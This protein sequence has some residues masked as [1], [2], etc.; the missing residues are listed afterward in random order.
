MRDAAAGNAAAG[1]LAPAGHLPARRVRAAS[2]QGAGAVRDTRIVIFGD[3]SAGKTRFLYASLNSLITAT[4]PAPPPVEFTDGES[5][6]QV[7][8]GLTAIRSGQDTVKTTTGLP[9]AVTCQLGTGHRAALA[10]LFDTAG[11]NYRDARCTTPSDS[12]TRGTGS[13]TSWT[14]SRSPGCATIWPGTTPRRSRLAH[15]AAGHPESAYAEVVSRIRDSGVP[16]DG[17]RLAVIIS[18]TDLLRAAGLDI[19]VGAAAIARWL[20]AIGMHN[21]VIGAQRDFAQVRYFTV[22]SQPV[23]GTGRQDDPGA[24]LRWLLRAYGT[25]LPGPADAADDQMTRTFRRDPQVPETA[26]AAT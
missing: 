5:G 20:Q 26:K 21:V 1:R 9:F 7:E 16:A 23:T 10:H 11:E 15:A 12:C 22:A 13:S 8:L 25:P 3:T 19:P 17:Q 2:P 4:E 6:R 14:R 24:P 18:K